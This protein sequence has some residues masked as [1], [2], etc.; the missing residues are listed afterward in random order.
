MLMKDADSIPPTVY[1]GTV[2]KERRKFIGISGIELGRRLNISQQQ[3]SRYER[4]VNC[5]NID[6]LIRFLS[7]L[8]MDGN[9]VNEFF[10]L[11]TYHYIGS[12]KKEE[13]SVKIR[14]QFFY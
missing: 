11:L 7:A 8:E 5:F 4:G 6:I 14:A 3:I 10:E 1:I 2:L 13:S 9:C 12:Q